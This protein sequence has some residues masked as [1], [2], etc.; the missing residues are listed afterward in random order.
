MQGTLWATEGSH[1]LFDLLPSSIPLQLIL[2]P[3][4]CLL[5]SCLMTMKNTKQ[6]SLSLYPLSYNQRSMWFL[7]QL[8]PESWAYNPLFTARIRSSVDVKAL[9][10]ALQSLLDRHSSLRS[11]YISFNGEPR[12]QIHQHQKVYFEQIDASTWTWEKLN[13][14][15]VDVAHRPFDLER[16]S[17]LRVSLFTC[18]ENDHIFLM[19]SHHVTVDA[20][21]WGLILDEIRTFYLIEAHN[22]PLSLPT[23]SKQYTDYVN[24]QTEMLA[25][26]AGKRLKEYWHKQLSGELPVLNMPTDRPRLPVQT[27]C[28]ASQVFKFSEELTEQVKKLAQ[29]EGTT[30]YRILLA[31]FLVLLYRYTGQEDI[32]VG[33]PTSGRNKSE[34]SRLVGHFVNPVVIRANF[35]K[36]LTFKAFL[37]Q[38]HFTMLSALMHQDYPFQLLV[39]QLQ[40][41]RDFSRSPIFQV[42]FN[43]PPV[44]QFKEL[45]AFFVQSEDSAK[46]DYAGLTL[47]PFFI[48]QQDGQLDLS[49]EIWE[50]GKSLFGIFKYNTDLFDA[51]T[52][53]NMVVHFQALLKGIVADT[54]QR[55]S[56]LPMLIPSEQYRLLWEWN[57]TKRK[58]SQDGCIHNLFA[59]QAEK[60]PDTVAVVFQEQ[61]LTYRELNNRANQ[62]ANYLQRLGVGREVLV[63]ISMKRSLEMVVALL[64]IL[65][66]NGAYV[67][68]DPMYPKERLAFILKDTQVQVLLT[69]QELVKELPEYDKELICV[70]TDWEVI[71]QQSRESPVNDV[72]PDNLAYVIY[73]SGSTG[74]PKGVTMIHR[75]LANLLCWQQESSKLHP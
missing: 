13:S 69:H 36:N 18:S 22:M 20:W 71:S 52:I 21:S 54:Q 46:I 26:P 1:G 44:S 48:A 25:K 8:A 47:E 70:D 4:F 23:L 3:E 33:V 38:V 45:S 14:C 31:T 73:T 72:T 58:Y 30:V 32:L 75:P 27:Y 35:A 50:I 68:L 43:M 39:E 6:T 7:H 63:G 28:G 12:Q 60:T 59:V 29:A 9:R 24:W 41:K 51:V 11:T 55:V 15:L 17:M 56:Q 74:K 42:L 19:S 66:A 53:E 61:Q 62:L 49:V 40:P 37:A 65:K 2:A 16:G 10:R 67:P 5:N 57:N 64:A 34:F